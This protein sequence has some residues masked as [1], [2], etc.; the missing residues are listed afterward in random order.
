MLPT[1]CYQFH[2]STGSI[3]KCT[4][5]FYGK[6]EIVYGD[7]FA[8]S[9]LATA[10]D[11][12]ISINGNIVDSATEHIKTTSINYYPNDV[13][14]IYEGGSS[15]ILYSM[16]IIVWHYEPEPEPEPEPPEPEPEPEILDPS[17]NYLEIEVGNIP[18]MAGWFDANNYNTTTKV[19]NDK[20][21]KDNNSYYTSGE[22]LLLDP[23]ID[24]SLNS[25]PILSGA[26]NDSIRLPLGNYY[27]GGSGY[28][29]FTFFF[30]ARYSGTTRRRIFN[31]LENNWHTGFDNANNVGISY[32]GNGGWVGNRTA[33]QTALLEYRS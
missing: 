5:T 24:S 26:L 7:S 8:T 16:T 19:W 21:G 29:D 23:I 27:Y 12:N 9:G 28:E 3:P 11:S 4:L 31:D 25:Y 33:T 14:R 20:S 17:L 18:N 10:P 30:V 1:I 2:R 15:V 22:P 6:I 32:H 13:L